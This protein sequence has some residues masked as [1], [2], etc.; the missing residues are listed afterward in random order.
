L[1][2]NVTVEKGKEKVRRG[3]YD[4]VVRMADA[5]H[6]RIASEQASEMSRRILRSFA[7]QSDGGE[8]A[9]GFTAVIRYFSGIGYWR[10][11]K[12]AKRHYATVNSIK[13]TPDGR[14]EVREAIEQML[15]KDIDMTAKEICV[16]LDKLGLSASFDLP[17]NQ[18]LNRKAETIH[19]G[20]KFKSIDWERACTADCVKQMISRVR[21]RLRRERNAKAWMKLSDRAL[22][23]GRPL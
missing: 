2:H 17:A 7:S 10:G 4:G 20:P 21:R 15:E 19:I 9:D 3:F 5:E 1:P 6:T 16:Q 18:K 13:R 22:P 12:N 8:L 11:Y 23:S 14:Q